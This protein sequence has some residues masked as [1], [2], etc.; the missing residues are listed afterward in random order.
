LTKELKQL[1]G[2]QN[3]ISDPSVTSIAA[4]YLRVTVTTAM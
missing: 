3:M 2:E 4:T 1:F